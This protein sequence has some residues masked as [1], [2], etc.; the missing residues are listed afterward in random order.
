MYM[1]SLIVCIIVLAAAEGCGRPADHRTYS[2]QGQVLALDVSRKQLTIKHEE[3]KGLM[4]AM[5]MPYDVKDQNLL[6]GL[7]PGDLVNAM[8]VIG[9]NE[10][11]LTAIKRVGNAP[12]E[13]P[14]A[15][16]APSPKA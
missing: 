12:L 16:T 11:H 13:K 8:L 10:A 4:P 5:T 9:S 6:N 2:L 15:D 7:A 14:P 3:I 1:R